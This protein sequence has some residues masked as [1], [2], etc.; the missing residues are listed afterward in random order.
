MDTQ[1]KKASMLFLSKEASDRD[2]RLKTEMMVC[3]NDD[4][5]DNSTERVWKENGFFGDHRADPTIKKANFL[6]NI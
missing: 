3:M 5:S 6:E 2:K 4:K 1:S